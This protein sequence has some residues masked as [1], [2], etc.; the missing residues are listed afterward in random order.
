[1]KNI[2]LEKS[3]TRYGEASP[4]LSRIYLDQKSE[5]LYSFFTERTRQMLCILT[6]VM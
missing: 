6:I 4:R 3:Y 1:M 2:V 5:K